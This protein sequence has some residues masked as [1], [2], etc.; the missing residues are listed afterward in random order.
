[1]IKL[2]LLFIFSKDRI[3]KSGLRLSISYIQLLLIY[4]VFN[5]SIDNVELDWINYWFRIIESI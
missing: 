1:M 3:I 4:S 5:W 2:N